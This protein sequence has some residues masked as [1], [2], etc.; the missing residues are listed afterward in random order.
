MAPGRGA[1][2][3]IQSPAGVAFA[4]GVVM[5]TVMPMRVAVMMMPMGRF[6]GDGGR[7]GF[8]RDRPTRGRA[9]FHRQFHFIR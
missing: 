4:G 9:A 1:L 7:V 2:F 6:E 8:I 3:W 5:M